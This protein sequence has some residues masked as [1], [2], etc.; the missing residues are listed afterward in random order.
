MRTHSDG[1]RRGK[2]RNCLKTTQA[3]YVVWVFS[4]RPWCREYTIAR[5]L[6][7]CNMP[8]VGSLTC[9]LLSDSH[10]L[11][12]SRPPASWLVGEPKELHLL[13]SRRIGAEERLCGACAGKRSQCWGSARGGL[14]SSGSVVA[15]RT[16]DHRP[17]CPRQGGHPSP[18][19]PEAR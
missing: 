2:L 4:W 5:G 16:M 3:Q 18:R 9:N 14:G 7:V 10:N 11:R 19:D 1:G 13:R 17:W 12:R 15:G 6:S 8:L